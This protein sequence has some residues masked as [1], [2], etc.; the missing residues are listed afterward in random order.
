MYYVIYDDE[1][2]G[3]QIM[4]EILS[5]NDA[6]LRVAEL[7]DDACVSNIKMMETRHMLQMMLKRITELENTV[8]QQERQIDDLRPRDEYEDD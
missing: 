1:Y 5:I 8:H 3:E 6:Q 4:E 7:E 2:Y